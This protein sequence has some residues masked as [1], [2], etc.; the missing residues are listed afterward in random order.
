MGMEKTARN[1]LEV[2]ADGLVRGW[3]LQT[4]GVMLTGMYR[5]PMLW[6]RSFSRV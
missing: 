4:I 6:S 1:I 3:G 5:P 2:A